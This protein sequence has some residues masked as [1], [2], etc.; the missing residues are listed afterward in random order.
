MRKVNIFCLPFAGGNRYSYREYEYK[1][2]SFLN[3]ICLEHPGRGGRF[4]ERLLTDIHLLAADLY[5]QVRP[6]LDDGDYAIYG[7]SMGG[8]MACLLGR[9]IRADNHAL[10]IHIFVTGTFGPSSPSREDK[11]RHLMP[12][13]DFIQ[14]IREL[15]GIPDEILQNEEM[16]DF[17]EPILRADFTATENYIY[18]EDSPLD[19][20]FTV[21]TGTEED[22]SAEDIYLWQKETTVPVDF[23]MLPGEHF[24]IF[25]HAQE[26]L[27]IISNKLLS[28][29][30]EFQQ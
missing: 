10:P 26:I 4:A 11:K 2:A 23:L 14:E 15:K 29:T 22:M 25:E 19:I 24:F 8:L 27:R 3:L 28:Q 9:M 17:L 13:P 12:K 20:P 5:Q 21:I 18:E 30:K 1:A 16:M 6:R 7:H